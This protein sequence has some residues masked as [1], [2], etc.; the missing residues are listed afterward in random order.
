MTRRDDGRVFR[1]WDKTNPLAYLAAIRERTG[2]PVVVVDWPIA[3][4]PSGSCYNSY[5]T[6]RTLEHYKAWL[7]TESRRLGLPLVDLS[8]VLLP[9]EYLDT[10]HPNPRGQRKIAAALAPHLDPV[11]RRR[12]AEVLPPA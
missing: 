9:R 12:I 4:E 7:G 2:I 3:H 5:L 8:R 1:G 10:L 11:L 6:K